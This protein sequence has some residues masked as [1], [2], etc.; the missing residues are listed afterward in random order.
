MEYFAPEVRSAM[1][2]FQ[3]FKYLILI[4]YKVKYPTKTVKGYIF[5]SFF[6]G[7]KRTLVSSERLL[8]LI[9]ECNPMIGFQSL[10]GSV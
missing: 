8:S 6:G 2:L 9:N 5:L 3:V 7:S 1:Y 4:A 10:L